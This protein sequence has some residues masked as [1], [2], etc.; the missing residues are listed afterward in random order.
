M[1]AIPSKQD[2]ASFAG[3]RP[4]T[5]GP[6]QV[7]RLQQPKDLSPPFRSFSSQSQDPFD[8]GA[9]R[10]NLSPIQLSIRLLSFAFVGKENEVKKEG[11]N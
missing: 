2:I 9:K 1:V 11:R 4:R 7:G 5:F 3:V 10:Q 6:G 8:R